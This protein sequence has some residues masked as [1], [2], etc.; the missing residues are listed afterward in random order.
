MRYSICIE[1]LH[2]SIMMELAAHTIESG[3]AYWS[4][5]VTTE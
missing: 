5:T 3:I 2:M 1:S 4:A